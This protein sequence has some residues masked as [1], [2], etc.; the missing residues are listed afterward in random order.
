M[1]KKF[2]IRNITFG[3]DIVRDAGVGLTFVK[4][5]QLHADGITWVDSNAGKQ[6]SEKTQRDRGGR[7]EYLKWLL[8]SINKFIG[9]VIGDAPVT[10]SELDQLKKAIL[11]NISVKDDRL[12]LD[13]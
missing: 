7:V 12:V 9:E 8:D 4:F 1:L 5:Y 13:P 11:E 2:V 3:I 10:D 6:W